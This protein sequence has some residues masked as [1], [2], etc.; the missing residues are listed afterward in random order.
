VRGT[1]TDYAVLSEDE[2]APKPPSLTHVVG[3]S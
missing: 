1:Y 3:A 2:L